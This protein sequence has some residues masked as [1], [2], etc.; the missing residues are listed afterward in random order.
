MKRFRLLSYFMVLFALLAMLSLTACDSDSDSSGNSGD[1]SNAAQLNDETLDKSMKWVDD[2]VPGCKL[3]GASALILSVPRMKSVE[4]Q[5]NIAFQLV[6]DVLL[7]RSSGSIRG[8]A[9]LD[10]MSGSIEGDCGGSLTIDEEH[11]NGDSDISIVFSSFCTEEAGEQTVTNG[12]LNA[13][14]KGDPGPDGPEFSSISASTPGALTVASPEE[15][16]TLELDNFSVSADDTSASLTIDEITIGLEKEGVTHSMS[17]V[18]ADMDEDSAGNSTLHIYSGRYNAGE[19]GYVD[20]STPTPLAIDDDG[21]LVS[22]EIN[23]EGAEGNTVALTPSSDGIFDVTLN[24]EPVD[25][26]MDCS[27]I[28]LDL[29]SF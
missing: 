23:F 5:P 15:T 13:S 4:K 6:A 29:L 17:D 20:I 27:E 2:T 22:G 26:R 10:G 3:E 7:G 12:T 28:S 1:S 25:Q 9:Y 19:E 24:G 16:V 11:A 18:S 14:I 8:L 21:A